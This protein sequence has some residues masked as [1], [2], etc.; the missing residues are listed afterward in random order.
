MV[1][2]VRPRLID[3]LGALAS[4]LVEALDADACGISRALGD[5]LLFVTEHAAP[6]RTLLSGSGYLVSE[7]PLTKRVLET[8]EP[9]AVCLDDTSA[10]EAEA[11]I[12]LELG[13]AS[14]LMLPLDLAG[15][16][17]GLVEVY[18]EEPRPFG[19]VEMRAAA[20]VL[21]ELAR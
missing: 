7:F 8:R 18:R 9:L 6:E 2:V 14:L 10:D 20:A 15:E 12:L 19:A 1:A 17:W 13:Y 3:S 5:V 21:A 16:P 11:R 4:T